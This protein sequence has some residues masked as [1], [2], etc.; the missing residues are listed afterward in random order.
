MEGIF[1]LKGKEEGFFS[2]GPAYHKKLV[3]LRNNVL[4]LADLSTKAVE[5]Q[6]HIGVAEVEHLPD[7]LFL[8]LSLPLEGVDEEQSTVELRLNSK[9]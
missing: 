6:V 2:L 9:A 1:E 3:K 7:T 5:K 8:K 4:S